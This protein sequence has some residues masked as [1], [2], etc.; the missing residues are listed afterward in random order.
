MEKLCQ[1]AKDW[2]EFLGI[3]GGGIMTAWGYISNISS[4]NIF[5]PNELFLVGLL[6]FLISVAI[7]VFKAKKRS[8]ENKNKEV[9]DKNDVFYIT[10]NINTTKNEEHKLP[11]VTVK[12]E[13]PERKEL[14]YQMGLDV[15]KFEMKFYL[16]QDQSNAEIKK[17]YEDAQKA[18]YS[19]LDWLPKSNLILKNAVQVR[20]VL[21]KLN[22]LIN[23][24]GWIIASLM[25]DREI[26]QNFYDNRNQPPQAII[27]ELIS[28]K[29]MLWGT[30]SQSYKSQINSSI[31][32]L[33]NLLHSEIN[34]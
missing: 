31:R 32:E 8:R 19:L 10:F 21:L 30:D 6:I 22:R 13:L 29:N 33:I 2:W 4:F 12:S 15:P 7:A 18:F 27:D 25:K 20:D 9:P 14:A 16:I 11:I 5:H 17:C 28:L 26:S 3:I 1:A 23:E 34:D 24:Y